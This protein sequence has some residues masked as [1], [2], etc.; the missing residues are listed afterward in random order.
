VIDET[1]LILAMR[2]AFFDWDTASEDAWPIVLQLLKNGARLND[3]TPEGTVAIHLLFE[4]FISARKSSAKELEGR[5][6]ELIEKHGADP[7]VPLE[8]QSTMLGKCLLLRLEDA[9]S[10]DHHNRAKKFAQYLL[11]RGARLCESELQA[12]FREWLNHEPLRKNKWFDM[13]GYGPSIAPSSAFD[14]Y[15]SVLLVTPNLGLAKKLSAWL[16]WPSQANELI[17]ELLFGENSHK[18]IRTFLLRGAAE[19]DEMEQ[20]DNENSDQNIGIVFDATGLRLLHRL[21]KALKANESYNEAQA[22]KDS[23]I[24]IRRGAT[25][26]DSPGKS[27]SAVQW[28]KTINKQRNGRYAKLL[29]LFYDT[30]DKEEGRLSGNHIDNL[31]NFDADTHMCTCVP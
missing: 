30:R 9:F 8:R 31:P 1:P 26:C 12:V 20:S 4:A 13:A 15:K 2:V 28:L 27:P 5:L 22:I 10:T 18:G 29:N 25:T 21:V 6:K 7:N 23:E 17:P 24:L 19:T 3:I 16:P 11:G 14:A